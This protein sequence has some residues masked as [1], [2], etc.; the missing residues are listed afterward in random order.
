ME[1]T[2][3]HSS[4]SASPALAGMTPLVRAGFDPEFLSNAEFGRQPFR[5]V[6]RRPARARALLS[7]GL[8]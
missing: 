2:L 8:R 7:R 3:R 6:R 4:A 1:M 5:V